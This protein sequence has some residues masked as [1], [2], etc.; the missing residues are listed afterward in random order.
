VRPLSRDAQGVGATVKLLAARKISVIVLQLG[1][2]DLASP[3]G[4]MMLT[5]WQP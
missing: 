2:L 5:W 1:K 3:A 4:K